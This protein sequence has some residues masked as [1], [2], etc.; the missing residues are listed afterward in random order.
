M[1]IIGFHTDVHYSQIQT[2]NHDFTAARV[3]PSGMP[4]AATAAPTDVVA[5]IKASITDVMAAGLRPFWEIKIAPKDVLSGKADAIIMAVFN[6]AQTINWTKDG[7]NS[8]GTY[9]HEPEPH[10]LGSD[11][12]NAYNYI[13]NK[14]PPGSKFHFGPVFQSYA[15]RKAFDPTYLPGESR[16]VGFRRYRLLLLGQ[17]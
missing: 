6:F 15:H 4:W 7:P 14:I 1:A 8:F 10:M 13:Q 11:F 3:F 2:A 17:F 9:W 12:V 5:K 16:Q